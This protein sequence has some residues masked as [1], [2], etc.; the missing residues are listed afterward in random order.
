MLR[1]AEELSIRKQVKAEFG[2][3][4]KEFVFEDQAF[5]VDAD[6]INKFLTTQERQSI[7]RHM[8]FNLRAQKGDTLGRIEFLE[9]QAVGESFKYCCALT[10][11]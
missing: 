8:L 5:F 9:G 11:P 1:G 4:T 2:G 7:V 10:L 6:D 3:G